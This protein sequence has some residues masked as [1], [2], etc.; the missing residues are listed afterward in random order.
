MRIGQV[1]FITFASKVVSSAAGFLATIYFARELGAGTLGVYYL[2]LSIVAWLAL[3]GSMG[4]GGAITKRLSEG[5]DLGAYKVGGGMIIAALTVPILLGI[6]LFEG[7]IHR[8]FGIETVG[9]IALLLVVGLLGS[10]VDAVLKG[11]HL[12]HVFAVLKPVRR[13]IRTAFQVGGVLVG[14]GLSALVFGYAFGGFVVVV[15][16]LFVIGGPYELPTKRHIRRLV[17]FAKYS[18]LGRLEGKTFNQADILLLGVFVPSALVGVYGVTWNIA[19][20]LTIFSSSISTVLF[21]EL[22]QRS[23]SDLDDEVATLVEDSLSYAGLFTIPGLVGGALLSDRILK[24]YGDE[25]VQGTQ[26]LA[27]LILAVLFYGY[28]NQFANTLGGIDRPDEAF[29]LNGLLIGSNIGLNVVLI[30][31]YGMVGAAIASVTSTLLA[32]G[33]GYL[34]TRRHVH[35]SIPA[36]PIGHQIVA[37]IGMGVVVFGADAGA[38]MVG[39]GWPNWIATV[40][41]VGAGGTTYFGLLAAISREFRRTV[42]QNLPEVGPLDRFG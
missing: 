30:P 1:S 26:V 12:V 41:L 38:E 32:T 14:F 17:D 34:I 18:W 15:V 9:Y 35:V 20:F 16:G 37:A 7:A 8:Y 24:L 22:S 5:V 13:I 42:I 23:F 33:G 2:L 4:V 29:K 3:V 25:F 27:L 6:V 21:P 39:V 40:V 19:I 10:Y 36:R 31:L 11:I 28:Q